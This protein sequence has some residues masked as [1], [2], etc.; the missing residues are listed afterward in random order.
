MVFLNACCVLALT[1]GMA[2]DALE[3]CHSGGAIEKA[4]LFRDCPHLSFYVAGILRQF[5][6]T[7]ERVPNLCANPSATKLEIMLVS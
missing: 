5:E 3:V 2:D 7:S 4:C 1:V 6:K